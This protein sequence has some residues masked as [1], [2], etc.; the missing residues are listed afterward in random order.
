MQ[1][2]KPSLPISTD[3]GGALDIVKE[4]VRHQGWHDPKLGAP[5]LVLTPYYLFSFTVFVE[6]ADK[7]RGHKVLVD[8]E[9]GS[10]ALSAVTG[11][12]DE[13]VSADIESGLDQLVH[14]LGSE[15]PRI[16]RS[17]IH[18]KDAEKIAQIKT[19]QFK[20]SDRKN[21]LVGNFQTI[22]YPHWLIQAKLEE[23]Q[24][25]FDVSAFSGSVLKE[26][27][28]PERPKGL[29]ELAEE[30]VGELRHPSSWVDYSVAVL[31]S[32]WNILTWPPFWELVF[33][34]LGAAWR[35]VTTN[36]M[37][38]ILLLVLIAIWLV[39]GGLR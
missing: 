35:A 2:G 13:A 18:R 27:E 15:N 4:E 21:A 39:F 32:I 29:G 9:T 23:E 26:P 36:R 34:I 3:G 14:D 10:L 28:I 1:T 11:E 30:T 6:E 17:V 24:V 37:V 5:K 12:I 19:A 7:E 31:R 16:E 22:L 25:E 20:Q 8:S 38:Q 33:G